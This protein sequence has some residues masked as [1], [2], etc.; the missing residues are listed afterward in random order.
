MV[1]CVLQYFWEEG[2]LFFRYAGDWVCLK[3]MSIGIL[4]N[5]SNYE[6]NL[7]LHGF[8]YCNLRLPRTC[9]SPTFTALHLRSKMKDL[10][11]IAPALFHLLLGNQKW[12]VSFQLLKVRGCKSAR[13]RC[14]WG[15]L[16]NPFLSWGSFGLS[17]HW[18]RW[19]QVLVHVTDASNVGFTQDA[20]WS[21]PLK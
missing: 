18:S 21:N 3:T 17:N 8:H 12:L 1:F 2:I 13:Y 7:F 14:K 9:F 15:S 16:K 19:K 4:E 20:Q 11:F 5:G 6:Y 10:I